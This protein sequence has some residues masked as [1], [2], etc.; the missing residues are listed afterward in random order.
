MSSM[1]RRH[2]MLAAT[3]LAAGSGARIVFARGCGP[4]ARRRNRAVHAAA[5]DLSDQCVRATDRRQDDG[6]PTRSA[7][8]RLC[9]HLN[10]VAKTN[11]QLGTRRS[12]T[13]RQSECAGRQHQFTAATISAAMPTHHVLEIWART[14]QAGGRGAGRH[15]P[16]SR[17]HAKKFR[18]TSTPR[19][20]QFGRAGCSSRSPRT[21]ARDR[22]RRNQDNPM[23]DGN[24]PDG[25]RRLGARLLPELPEPPRRLSEG[26]VEYGDWAKIAERMRA[27]AGTLGA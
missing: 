10:N 16:R 26:V 17:R 22:T 27:K 24:A 21:E 8:R 3:G 7:P 23:M 18:T 6:K 25:Q 14:R 13:F 5:A 4:G 20:R 9:R 19:R 15:R 1:S 2:L 11:P 12:R